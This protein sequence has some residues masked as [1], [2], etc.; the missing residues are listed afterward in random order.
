MQPYF[1]ADYKSK[2]DRLYCRIKIGQK[3]FRSKIKVMKEQ[4]IKVRRIILLRLRD[5]KQPMRN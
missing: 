5:L 1:V 4:S 3:K 2:S